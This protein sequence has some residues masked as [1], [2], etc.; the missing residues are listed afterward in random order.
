[1]T[2]VLGMRGDYRPELGFVAIYV[3]DFHLF[4]FVVAVQG[5]R[6]CFNAKERD[7]LVH[8]GYRV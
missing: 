4:I 3:G 8:T 1:M 5:A 7:A 2:W 6:N